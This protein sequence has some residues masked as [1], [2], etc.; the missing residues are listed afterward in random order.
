M[1][2]NELLS[3]GIGLREEEGVQLRRLQWKFDIIAG[4]WCGY[5]KHGKVMTFAPYLVWMVRHGRPEDIV[6][7][8]RQQ[9]PGLSRRQ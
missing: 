1:R 2:I 8:R 7:W 4:A 6:E 5:A 3:R 9:R